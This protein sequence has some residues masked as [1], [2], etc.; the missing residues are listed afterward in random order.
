MTRDQM[1]RNKMTRDQMTHDQTTQS[2]IKEYILK[3]RSRFSL[4]W[5]KKIKVWV[6][7]IKIQ[8]LSAAF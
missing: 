2:R 8:V 4:F 7:S 1:T 5:R 3:L 6:K